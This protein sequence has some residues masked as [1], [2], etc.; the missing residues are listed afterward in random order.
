MFSVNHT[1]KSKIN[2]KFATRYITKPETFIKKY[3]KRYFEVENLNRCWR[4][5]FI[6]QRQQNLK[7]GVYNDR[8]R[9]P[10]NDTPYTQNTCYNL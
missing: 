3:L 5:Q 8:W 10:I 1:E 9:T 6:G 7:K 4:F 2:Y